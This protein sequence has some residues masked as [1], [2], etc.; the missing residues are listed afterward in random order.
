MLR[1]VLR[2]GASAARLQGPRYRQ[3]QDGD[4]A[5]EP[6]SAT[7]IKKLDLRRAAEEEAAATRNLVPPEPWHEVLAGKPGYFAS[8][9]SA[10]IQSGAR[11]SRATIVNARKAHQA[12][13]PVPIV[14]IAERVLLRGLT[15]WILGDAEPSNDEAAPYQAFVIGPLIHKLH[16]VP[17][18]LNPDFEAMSSDY[19]VQADIA[20]FYQYVDHSVLLNELQ[21]QT[22]NVEG[23]IRLIELLAEV[24]GTTYGLPQL[25]DPSDRLAELYMGI[26]E[27]DL[28][29][30]GHALW[31]YNDDF[32]IS[33]TGYAAALQ[34]LEDL[35]SVAHSVGLILNE[36]KTSIVK[37]KTY[38]ERHAS[39][40]DLEEGDD[41]LAGQAINVAISEYSDEDELERL[42]QAVGFVERIDSLAPDSIDLKNLTY[43]DVRELRRSLNTLRRNE[44]NAAV[45][46]LV[47]IARFVPQLT[48]TMC[49]YLVALAESDSDATHL[50]DWS[51]IALR[52]GGYNVWQRAWLV[53]VARRCN[54]TSDAN[55]RGWIRDQMAHSERTLLHAEAAL[56]LAQ[57]D[58]IEFDE[59]DRYL[60]TQ[61]EPLV[62]WYL[63]ALD[64]L[65][66]V[67]KDRVEAVR[68]SS[69]LGRLLLSD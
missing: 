12:I 64:A 23:S 16:T 4:Q 55:C 50:K 25:L 49:N 20:A 17:E 2:A 8:W 67:S 44:N 7:Q 45:S 62:G 68:Q 3:D 54:Y 69:A 59:L 21:M 53:Y 58:A 43:E 60:R 36:S 47:N 48:P 56:A 35:S 22:E 26:V 11:N 34:V 51:D 39:T 18:W 15:N 9:V 27:R 31:R 30:R 41:L 6:L 5:V 32:R 65:S 24:Q 57:V 63:L 14:G 33:V 13:R 46:H 38:Y 19:V 10:R 28:R 40:D 66:G 61:P 52:S 42:Q 29:R 37:F 1:R